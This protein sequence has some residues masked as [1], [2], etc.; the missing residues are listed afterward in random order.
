M[1]MLVSSSNTGSLVSW[2]ITS[3]RA[4]A[5]GARL[6]ARRGGVPHGSVHAARGDPSSSLL[7]MDLGLSGEPG[8]ASTPM[9]GRLGARHCARTAMVVL[10]VAAAGEL[11]QAMAMRR[12]GLK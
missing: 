7:A 1:L 12:T 2:S 6:L 4:V 8:H 9:I 3:R 5:P 10:V 11:G